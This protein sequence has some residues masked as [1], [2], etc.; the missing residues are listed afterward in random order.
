MD[1]RWSNTVKNYRALN[2]DG[3]QTGGNR[4]PPP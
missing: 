3:I 4:V 2:P 1:Q